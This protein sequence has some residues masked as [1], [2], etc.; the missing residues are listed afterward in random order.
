MFNDINIVASILP[1]CD[2]IFIDQRLHDL[3]SDFPDYKGKLFSL[4]NK[5]KFLNYLERLEENVST[6][7]KELVAQIYPSHK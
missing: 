4:N 7:Y 6:L 1:Y 3:F 5:E 2:A